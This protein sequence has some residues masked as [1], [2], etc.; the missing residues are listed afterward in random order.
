VCPESRSQSARTA[1]RRRNI[2]DPE[3]ALVSF[4][5]RPLLLAAGI[6]AAGPAA[7]GL[8][9]YDPDGGWKS[10]TAGMGAAVSLTGDLTHGL[11]LVA[12]GTY[13]RL[14]GDTADSP[15]VATAG[16]RN[17]WMGALGLAYSF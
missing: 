5:L 9:A 4:V 15:I 1:F 13:R 7:S 16:S 11:Q 12:A 8:P 14:L 2:L 10:W 6:A 3:H 17:Q